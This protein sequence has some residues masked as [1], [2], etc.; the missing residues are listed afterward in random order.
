[1]QHIKKSF[2]FILL[3]LF[4]SMT[5]NT[6]AP[7]TT[8]ESIDRGSKS[9]ETIN[10]QDY[11]TIEIADIGNVVVKLCP[12]VAPNHGARIL[13]LAGEK[14]YDGLLFHRAIPGFMVQTG[15]PTGKGSGGS[16]KPNLIAEF[17]NM[18]HKRGVLSMARTNDPNSANSQFFIMLADHPS[19]NNQYSA[20]GYVVSGME[21]VDQIQMGEESRN[22]MVYNPSIIKKMYVGVPKDFKIIG[23]TNGCEQ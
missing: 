16:S 10:K 21:F 17:S 20:F 4:T 6:D 18:Q 13:E 12:V 7:A 8:D 14:F 5:I 9:T 19:L 11:V 23:T 3:L 15:D 1:M 2:Y 22:G